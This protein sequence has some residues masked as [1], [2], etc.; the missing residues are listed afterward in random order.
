M[1]LNPIN[2]EFHEVEVKFRVDEAMRNDWK[3]LV[4][5][6]DGL[7][8]HIYTESDDIYYT[9]ND[10]FLRYRFSPN[11]K[12]KR[13]EITYKSK[14]NKDNNIIR[15]EVNLRIDGNSSE[16]VEAFVN[17][18]GFKYNFLISKYIDIYKFDDV[19]L[20]FYTVIDEN[21]KRDTFIEIEVN[22]EKIHTLTENECWDIIKKY[23][24]ILSPLGITAQK[25]LRKSLFEIYRKES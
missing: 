1:D 11:K 21:G 24:S 2:L 19:T 14:I 13:A 22:E 15:K 7:K 17:S 18:L 5:K 23:E 8:E 20:P 10:E 3:Q 12:E 6:I 25:R 16:T 9:N 4:E